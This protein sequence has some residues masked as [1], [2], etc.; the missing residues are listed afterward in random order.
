M[1][2]AGGKQ[3]FDYKRSKQ[4]KEFIGELSERTGI[5]GGSLIQSDTRGKMSKLDAQTAEIQ[6]LL[7]YAKDTSKKLGDTS[8]KL[9]DTSM[10][11]DRVPDERVDLDGI[12][13]N[14][15]EQLIILRA[16]NLDDDPDSYKL[17]AMRRQKQTIGKSIRALQKKYN[18]C[19]FRKW[20][21]IDHPNSKALWNNFRKVY[22][23]E[24]EFDDQ[25]NMFDLPEGMSYDKFEAMVQYLNASRLNI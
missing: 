19:G 9:D 16:Y 24:F 8:K 23:D 10:K 13:S 22:T 25:S 15:H 18:G 5:P 3:W 4:T 1:C 7:G 17:Y 14:K 6:K 21:T 12:P 11:L 2:K 20:L